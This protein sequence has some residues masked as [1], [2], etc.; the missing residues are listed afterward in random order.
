MNMNY[1]SA[2]DL[3]VMEIENFL[4]RKNIYLLDKK[5]EISIL[6]REN[7]DGKAKD[8]LEE[9]ILKDLKEKSFNRITTDVISAIKEIME[10]KKMSLNEN[11][12]IELYFHMKKAIDKANKY[13]EVKEE[14][15][16]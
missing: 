15:Y 11:T 13:L 6:I 9:I 8:T 12:R 7:L 5:D 4:R 1:C 14:V 16:A 2:K 3:L 10:E